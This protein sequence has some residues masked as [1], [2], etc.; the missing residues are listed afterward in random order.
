MGREE[1]GGSNCH[2]L[3]AVVPEMEEGL[4]REL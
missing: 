4:E 2:P 1:R 3:R